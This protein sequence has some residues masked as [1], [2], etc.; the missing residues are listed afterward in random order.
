MNGIITAAGIRLDAEGAKK[1][2]AWFRGRDILATS[3]AML[4]LHLYE[5]LPN[6]AGATI[7]RTQ[8]LYDVLHRKPNLT[9]AGDSFASTF[10]SALALGKSIPEALM[11]G[12]VNSMSVV[13][14]IGAQEGLL[15]R[16]QLE[17]FLR[18]A[19]DN[20]KPRQIK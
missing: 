20:Y 14:Y 6:D 19:P 7:A 2:S 11:W 1:I 13:Q 3:L 15:S 12:P 4:P 17:K 9:G 8:P 10:T 18:E 16:S 5:R